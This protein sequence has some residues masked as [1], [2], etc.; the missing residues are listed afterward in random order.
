MNEDKSRSKFILQLASE[1]LE[2]IELNRLETEPLLLKATRL[3]R[4]TG[5]ETIQQ[6]LRY[7]MIGYNDSES[8]ARKYLSL[9]GRWIDDKKKFAYWGPLAQQEAA[10]K[11]L[12]LRLQ[13]LR[14]PDIS[15]SVASSNPNEFVTLTVNPASDAIDKVIKESRTLAASISSISAVRSRVIGLLHSFV[16]EIYYEALFSDLSESIFE[17]YQ[18]KVDGLLAERC[19]SVLEK[20]P[21]IYKRLAEG[22]AESVSH[23]LTTCRRIIDSFADEIYPAP[24]PPIEKDING[25]T[26]RLGQQERLNRIEAYIRTHLE[27]NSRRKKL[28]QSLDNLYARVCTGVH[29]DVSTDEASSLFL[30][31]YLILGEV[32]AIPL[33]SNG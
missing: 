33:N 23:A 31:T 1:L 21:A 16:A 20:V 24:D 5:S 18:A 7:E 3:A 28:R 19:G 8:L 6:W 30:E 27:S 17:Q 14:V 2:D 11:A 32:L 9:T 26:L 29:S 15:H 25:K 12:N 22:D 10:I 13:G 4:L